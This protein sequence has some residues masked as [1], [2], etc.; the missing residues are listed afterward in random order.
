MK[1]FLTEFQN[2]I[3]I[4]F[5]N[6]DLLKTSLTHKSFNNKINNEKLEFLGDRVLGIVLSNKLLNIYPQESVGIIDKKF[7]NIV[8]KK[9]CAIIAKKME[10]KKYMITGDSNKGSDR[11]DEKIISDGLEALIGAIYLDKGLDVAE[12]F[13]SKHWKDFLIK[14]SVLDIDSKTKLQEYSLK[15][16]KT[17]PVYKFFKQSGPQHRPIFKVNVQINNSKIFSATGAS[18]KI[19][20]QNAAKKLIIDLKI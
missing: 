3:S 17:L 1:N 5:N 6:I 8:N 16:F 12:K 2:V 9:T 20:E 14:S 13:I 19:A 15:K 7:A 4:K 10:L 11:S 18:K